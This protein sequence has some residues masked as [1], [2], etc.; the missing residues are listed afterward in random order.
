MFHWSCCGFIILIHSTSFKFNTYGTQKLA[1]YSVEQMAMSSWRLFE[2]RFSGLLLFC[3][4]VFLRL[5]FSELFVIEKNTQGGLML[6]EAHDIRARVAL[7]W[8][9]CNCGWFIMNLSQSIRM[10]SWAIISL[11]FQRESF[12]NK[13]K[14]AKWICK[15]NSKSTFSNFTPYLSYIE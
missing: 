6:E 13:N 14:P 2:C 3:C 5:N 10:R 9:R 11:K 8:W 4:S 7:M 12:L 1:F 15:S